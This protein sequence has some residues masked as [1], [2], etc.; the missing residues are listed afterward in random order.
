MA[1]P[2]TTTNTSTA[3]LISDEIFTSFCRYEATE[4]YSV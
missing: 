4:A 1:D 3:F 2:K